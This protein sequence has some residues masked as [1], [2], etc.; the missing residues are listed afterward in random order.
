MSEVVYVWR[1]KEFR[2]P[3]VEGLDIASPVGIG[4]EMYF[5]S[6]EDEEGNAIFEQVGRIRW[7]DPS[8]K[9]VYEVTYYPEYDGP[10]EYESQESKDAREEYLREVQQGSTE[11]PT[12]E[13]GLPDTGDN[14]VESV[15]SEIV[16][17]GS[18]GSANAA[19]GGDVPTQ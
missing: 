8:N 19:T 9:T 2:T 12:E 10:R 16:S 13:T 6:G 18:D 17:L 3:P 7:P 4:T 1:P 11:E 14:G 15:P 5:H